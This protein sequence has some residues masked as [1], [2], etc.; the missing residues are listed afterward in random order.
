MQPIPAPAK[1]RVLNTDLSITSLD[2]AADCIASWGL[3]GT[4]AR[5]CICNVHT[6]MESH[7]D[8]SYAACLNTAKMATPD[9]VP[10]VWAMRKRG[11]PEQQRVYGPDLLERCAERWSQRKGT[12]NQSVSSF[13]FG[14]ADGVAQQLATSLQNRFSGFDVAGTYSPPFRNLS[15]EEEENIVRMINDS[16][17][18]VVWVGLGAPKQERWMAEHADRIKPVMIGVGAAFDFLTGNIRQAPRWVMKL[19]LEWA[20]RLAMEPRR[21]WRRYLYNNPY[22]LWYLLRGCRNPDDKSIS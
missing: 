17:A 20:F 5:V 21:L 9:G 7:R 1:C 6:V 22:F 11:H 12:D 8:P 2:N 14:A 3:S 15:S 19:G 16:G 18:Q 13:F 10:L 4:P